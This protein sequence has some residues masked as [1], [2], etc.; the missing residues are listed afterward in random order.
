MTRFTIEEPTEFSS[1]LLWK[2]QE[3]AYREFGPAAWH[4]KGVPFYATSNPLIA[5]QYC[6]LIFAYLQDIREKLDFTQP[7]YLLDLGAG[8]GQLGYRILRELLPQVK[9]LFP[10]LKLRYIMTDIVETNLAFLEGHSYLHPFVAEGVLDFSNFHH[11]DTKFILRKQKETLERFVNPIGVICNYFFDTIPQELYR[12]RKG[13]LEA[14]KVSLFTEEQFED[15]SDPHIISSL[16]YEYS[17]EEGNIPDEPILREYEK[18]HKNFV[19]TYPKAAFQLL[20][21]LS[22]IAGGKLLLLAAD[23]ARATEAQLENWESVK[24]ALHGTFSVEVNYDAFQRYFQLKKGFGWI[25]PA[26]DPYFMN[27]AG[28][29]GAQTLHLERALRE[30]LEAFGPGDYCR[31]PL[32]PEQSLDAILIHIKMG[33]YDPSLFYEY[34]STIV[35]KALGIDAILRERLV[36]ATEK[37]FHQFYPICK[38]QSDFVMNLG[39][40]LFYLGESGGAKQ[41]FIAARNLGGDPVK[42]DLYIQEC[43]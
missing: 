23:Q 1:S 34:Y 18:R 19:F 20:D 39:V 24:I 14:G 21:R 35:K 28:V 37:A 36:T 11:T 42:L 5:S 6:T 13:K 27:F 10:K 2:L 8:T 31:M 29:L 25:D 33:F 12:S 9:Q 7:F 40:L 38:E 4:E 32:F 30:T 16:Q 43:E 17:Y 26:S 41:L 15:S 22:V 3:K